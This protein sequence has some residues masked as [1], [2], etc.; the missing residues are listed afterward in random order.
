MSKLRSVSTSFW[1]DPYIEELSPSQKL[2]YLYLITN[3][4]TNMLG[5]YEVSFRKI[6]FDTGVKRDDI[7]KAFDKFFKDGKVRYEHNYVIL[8]NFLK[9]QKFNTNMKKSAIDI[10]NELPNYLKTNT[11][12]LSKENPFE[13]FETLSKGMRMVRKVE[14]EDETES[15]TKKEDEE[16][17]PTAKFSMYKKLISLGVDK[18][19]T[20][21]W[22]QVRKNK[23]STNTQTALDGF[24]KAVSKSNLTIPEAVKICVENSWS[25]FNVKW[26]DNLNKTETNGNRQNNQKGARSTQLG[27]Q[28]YD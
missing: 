26:L 24:K 14:V 5:V 11:E 15:E 10:Y 18:T 21:E 25:G 4:K 16:E 27:R 12:V 6:S 22:L 8:V 7:E 1:S 20:N 9:H 2:L 19:L 28:E 23:K 17:T 13:S 3:D